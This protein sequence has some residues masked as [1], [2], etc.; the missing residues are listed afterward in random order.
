MRKEILRLRLQDKR[1]TAKVFNKLVEEHDHRADQFAVL[2][3]RLLDIMIGDF[4]RHFDQWKWITT[5]TGKG[6]LYFPIPRDRVQAFFYSDGKL[7]Q[8]SSRNLLPFLQGF[9]NNIPDVNWLGYPARDF[10]RVF[11]TDLDETDSERNHCRSAT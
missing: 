2:R 9:R 5:D 3:A 8:A 10:D 6:K 4:D 1:S 7:L 11:L